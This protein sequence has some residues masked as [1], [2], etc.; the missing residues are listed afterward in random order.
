MQAGFYRGKEKEVR[1]SVVMTTYNRAHRI[2]DSTRSILAQS[3]ADFELIIIDDGSTDDTMRVIDA[4]DD[5]RI[6]YTHQPNQGVSAARNM[7]ISKARGD[8]IAFCDS[9]DLLEPVSLEYFNR[10]AL[11]YPHIDFFYAD[12]FWQDVQQVVPS[13]APRFIPYVPG[14][15]TCAMFVRRH[16]LLQFDISIK[17]GLEDWFMLLSLHNKL[18]FKHLRK[19]VGFVGRNDDS[20]VLGNRD[21]DYISRQYQKVALKHMLAQLSPYPKLMVIVRCQDPTTEKLRFLVLNHYRLF[22]KDKYDLVLDASGIKDSAAL[23]EFGKAGLKRFSSREEIT[24]YTRASQPRVVF[25]ALDSLIIS[26]DFKFGRLKHGAR[27]YPWI[28]DGWLESVTSR[29]FFTCYSPNPLIIESFQCNDKDK[30]TD[31]SVFLCTLDT[32][33]QGKYEEKQ[34]A[35]AGMLR[36]GYTG[37]GS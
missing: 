8:F 10:H 17:D 2:S 19:K 11:K 27:Y 22:L 25:Q 16:P 24:E 28:V 32:Y 30:T 7:G 33:L 6:F 3:Y 34:I 36:L 21:E 15:A 4:F 14:I 23:E 35:G 13:I 5:P 26:K 1:I 12:A 31:S 9:D 29:S 20:H 18:R 37:A